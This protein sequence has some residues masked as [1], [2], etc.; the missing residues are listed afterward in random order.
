MSHNRKLGLFSVF[1]IAAGAMISSGLFVLPGLAF[2]KAGAGM[3]VAYALAAVL[4][5]PVLFSKAELGTAMP[6]A[7][8][9]Y[10]FIERSLGPLMGTVAGFAS[11]L[12]VALKAT[13]ALVGFGALLGQAFGDHSELF[14]KEAAVGGCV[15]FAI[16]N[17]I[18]TKESGRFQSLLVVFLVAILASYGLSA[19]PRVEETRYIPFAPQG[20]RAVLAVAGMV[21]V[22]FGGLT[23]VVAVAE[24]VENPNRNLP[25]GMFLAFGIVSAL[26]IL[27]VFVTVGIVEG[28]AL[29]GSMIPLSLGARLSLGS[30]GPVLIGVAAML[31]FI[32]TANSGILAASR[33]P[34][35][36]ARDGLVPKR[37]CYLSR[38]ATPTNAIAL[39][40]AV[41]ILLILFL[42][43][44]GL[45]KAA[46]TMMLLMFA[47]VNASVIVL[48]ESGI[49][50]YR[51]TF[52][53]PLY[54][55]LQI[56][57]ILAYFVLILEM[58][59]MPL[60][61]SA[62]FVVVALFWY[63]GYV[64][65]RIDRQSALMFMVKR[66]LSRHI[67]R[68]RLDEELVQILLERDNI[69]F[70][71]F[72]NLVAKCQ[73]LDLKESVGVKE[74]FRRIADVLPAELGLTSEEIYGLFLG[75]EREGSTVIQPGLA[76]P[77]IIVPGE[78][79]FDLV[80]VR[81]KEGI[82]FSELHAPVKIAF[83]L[84]GSRD[85]RNYHLRALMNIAQ[86][87]QEEG[88]EERW[89]N[90]SDANQLRDMVLLS[91][92]ARDVK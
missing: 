9:S 57:A 76:I 72:D 34:L 22:S 36:M 26:Y 17:A 2:E 45:V 46:S 39:T 64:R 42:D 49:E 30:T 23:K 28:Q 58:G 68:A 69:S 62:G 52:K 82:V 3:I 27:T 13:F 25:G 81:C 54:P 65:Q 90:A 71:R 10:F 48:R 61:L 31:A 56:L 12:S 41:M 73:I 60:L 21:F 84:I 59:R 5:I 78:G 19:L 47:L 79:I 63:F 38:R 14:L 44:E 75:R 91:G 92:R 8:G 50:N 6:K 70:D 89:L 67:K 37:L 74:L 20:W 15:I 40:A 86:I 16:L 51:P 33:M 35:A 55:Y 18:S 29:S 77:H 43:L 66:I 1:S 85:E 87:V 53:A 32:T 83:V 88:F 24:D 4:A 7:G 80:L 11:W